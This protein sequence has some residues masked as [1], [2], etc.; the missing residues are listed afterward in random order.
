M[1][2]SKIKK[3]FS[4]RSKELLTNSLLFAIGN[5]GTKLI[6]L[7]MVPVYTYYLSTSDYGQ[8]DLF[9]TTMTM[10]TPVISLSIFDAVFRFTLDKGKDDSQIFSNSIVVTLIGGFITCLI[11]VIVGYLFQQFNIMCFTLM[12]F[13]NNLLMFLMNFYRGINKIKSFLTISIFSA[14]I[15]ASL[16]L[17]LLTIYK[18][19]E[20]ILI[21][22][23]L[24]NLV[25]IVLVFFISKSRAYWNFQTVSKEKIFFLLKYS[26]PLI[27]NSFA[28]WFTSDAARFLILFFVG[29]VGN[30]IYG[31]ASK[32]PAALTIFFTI[33]SQAW[34]ISAINEYKAND[35]ERY[36][37]KVFNTL[38]SLSFIGVS[39]ILTF[40][41]PIIAMLF[42]T[43]YFPAW[44]NVPF[45][46][47]SAV[48]SNI[49]AFLGTTYIAS[50]KTGAIMR[51]TIIGM[52]IN[53]LLSG[54]LIFMIGVQGAG[55]GSMIGFL[56][57]I[58]L[59]LYGTKELVHIRTDL[60]KL[61]TG[62][63]LISIQI[64]SLWFV[65]DSLE[66]LIGVVITSLLCIIWQRKGNR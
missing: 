18:N 35:R 50:S 42:A 49:S 51:T 1:F 27:P 44:E 23:T 3:K 2:I 38:L 62:L 13:T 48:F 32:I 17:Y 6:T 45:L 26:I 47:L 66:L 55:I 40:L 21:G 29:T 9:V 61:Y 28:W 15:G 60:F 58:I 14:V 16:S 10:L 7:I 20:S 34:Q 11:G 8:L 63:L 37:S 52:I 53:A 59:R 54:V 46:L 64:F 12:L 41:K 30:G 39:L 24:G 22:T 43:R 33:F 4:N 36:Y 25:S 56:C 19:V 5:L 31:V 65:N 57:V